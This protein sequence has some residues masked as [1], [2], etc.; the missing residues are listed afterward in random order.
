MEGRSRTGGPTGYRVLDGT[1]QADGTFAITGVPD[2]VKYILRLGTGYYVTDRHTID[3]RIETAVRCVPPPASNSIATVLSF[4]MSNTTRYSANFD[5]LDGMRPSSFNA[6]FTS[7]GFP[8]TVTAD[9]T[10]ITAMAST[11]KNA[12]TAHSTARIT[13]ARPARSSSR[14]RRDT[15]HSADADPVARGPGRG[16]RPTEPTGDLRP[17]M[18]TP[19]DGVEHRAE[20]D[21]RWT[22]FEQ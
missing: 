5:Q 19:A 1:G 22:S 4:R 16:H 9:D 6:A 3:A 21:G 20:L 17:A 12:M 2:G 13:A 15:V 10:V 7:S 11:A 14:P 18:R 8:F